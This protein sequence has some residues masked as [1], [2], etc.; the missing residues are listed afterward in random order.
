MRVAFL[1]ACA[2]GTTLGDVDVTEATLA[3]VT[4]FHV[5]AVLGL[6]SGGATLR[7]QTTDGEDLEVPVAL[8]GPRLGLMADVAF[9]WGMV[10]VPLVWFGDDYG[11][12]GPVA[13]TE[14]LGTYRGL[15]YSAVAGVGVHYGSLYNDAG[16]WMAMNTLEVGAAGSVNYVWLTVAEQ[17]E[18]LP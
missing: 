4:L 8:S 17:N 15:E 5:G 10:D 14:L 18:G 13:G 1:L 11:P 16:V 3:D 12:G 9:G 2:A 6:E 7:V